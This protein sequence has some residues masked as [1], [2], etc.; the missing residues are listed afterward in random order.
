MKC[1]YCGGPLS[2]EEEYCPHCGALN[3]EARQHIEDMK[4]YHRAFGR[5]RSQVMDETGRQSRRH[6]R[7]FTVVLLV[8][9]N[10]IL[11]TGHNAMYELHYWWNSV[12]VNTHKDRHGGE[13]S[14]L[15]ADGDYRGLKDYYNGRDLYLVDSFRE[16]DAV[17]YGA[18]YY[19]AIYENIMRL[20]DPGVENF[21]YTEG[22]LVQR[23][24]ENIEWFY[25]QLE[26][27]EDGYHP[28]WFA[29]SHKAALA[30]MEARLRAML[31]A[32]CNMS[33]QDLDGMS[34]MSSQELMLLIGR[35]MGLYE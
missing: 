25:E 35:R 34:Q 6:G 27:E 31:A 22:E 21:Y 8:L 24:A 29:G 32:Y 1:K 7:V 5:T 17:E 28:E 3:Q 9:F 19:A 15:E 2:I 4:R 23:L 13:L 30:D 10:A 33:G 11:L 20:W 26:R 18:Q 16:F 14:R 12:Q